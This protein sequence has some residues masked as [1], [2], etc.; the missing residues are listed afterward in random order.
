VA[1]GATDGPGDRPIR[2]LPLGDSITQGGR[3]DR[4][5]HTYRWPLF[6]RL[7]EAGV[8]FD[9]IGSRDGGLHADARWPAEHRGVPFDPDHEGYYGR[10]TGTMADD[11]ARV[12]PRWSAPPDI[13]LIHLGTNDQ[14]ADDLDAAIIEPLGRIVAQLREAN[15]QVVVLL[16]HLNFNGG[17]ALR[18][19]PRVE[20]LAEALDTPASPVRTV[21]HYR[22]WVE[23]P[24]ADDADTFDWAHPNPRGQARMAERWHE[25]MLPWLDADTPPADAPDRPHDR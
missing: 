12:V 1:S 6:C 7:V 17:A 11:L 18:I 8:A 21:H 25:A 15:P 4:A 20:A 5:E 14:K 24:R 9:F 13:A 10:R 16:G 2:I 23:D 3:R 19:R 22:G